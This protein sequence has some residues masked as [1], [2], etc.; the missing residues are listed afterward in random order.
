MRRVVITGMGIWSSI[1]QDLKTVTESLRLGRSGI[2]FDSAR[3]EYGL[4]SGLVG[5]VPRP[6]LKSYLSRRQR[7]MMSVDAEYAYMAARQA[8]EQAQVTEDYLANNN[9]GIILGNDGN[10]H[11]LDSHEIMKNEHCSFL[12]GYNTAFRSMT[13]S[14]VVNLASIFHAR[15]IN[16]CVSSSCASACQ[17]LGLATMFIRSGLENMILV[18]GSAE[19][20]KES[21]GVIVND[22]ILLDARY[23]K[24]PSLASRPFDSNAVGAILSGGGSALV[25]E[26]YEHALERGATILAEIVSYGYAGGGLDVIYDVDWKTDY[27]AI[28]MALDEAGIEPEDIDFVHAR[29]D[30]FPACDKAE[31]KALSK[32]FAD[33]KIP[34]S[35]TDSITG[36]ECWTAGT[37]R[38]VYSILMMCNGFITPTINLENPIEEACTLNIIRQTTHKPLHTV[39]LNSAGIG[40]TN[41][42]IILRKL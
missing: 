12:V 1:G 37:N 10:I 25:L 29:A 4:Q 33:Y 9:V 11:Q 36:H 38:I 8:F 34:I 21:V 13:S 5:D 17:A 14:A 18:G 32:I 19:P 41:C 39:L 20:A 26:D 15:G 42:A 2:V 28:K 16:L 24:E 23:N 7:Q 40:G 30:S 22:A 35:S 6:D 31:A 3:V 27:R